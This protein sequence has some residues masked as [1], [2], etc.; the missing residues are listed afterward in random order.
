MVSF[1]WKKL[2]YYIRSEKERKAHREVSFST[3]VC[4][5]VYGHKQLNDQISTQETQLRTFIFVLNN[6]NH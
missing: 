5:G 3:Q 2:Y 6:K 1:H 4:I